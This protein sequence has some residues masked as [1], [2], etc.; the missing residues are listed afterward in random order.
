MAQSLQMTARTKEAVARLGLK[1]DGHRNERAAAGNR[2]TSLKQGEA[3]HARPNGFR[4]VSGKSL[5]GMHIAKYD[6]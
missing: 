2:L 4:A 6:G 1:G 3:S 5:G